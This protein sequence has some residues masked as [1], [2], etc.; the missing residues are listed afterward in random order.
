MNI[1]ILDDYQQVVPQLPCFSLLKEHQVQVFNDTPDS[2]EQ[3]VARLQHYE[4]L[5][6]IRERT[7]IDRAL[8][9]Q[10][11]NLRLIS[12][13]GRLSGHIDVEACTEFGVAIAEGQGSPV[14]PAEL[15]WA[16]VMAASRHIV[17]Y[18]M[19][20]QAGMW[21]SN[22]SLGLGRSLEGLTF[23][24]W[25]YGKIG[26]RIARYAQAFGM[27]VMI[28][29]SE[30]S[31]TLAVQDGFSAAP[32]RAA[33]FEQADI[34][35]LH[36]RLNE[37]TRYSVTQEDL[38]RM[39]TDAL[40][41]NI[42]RAELIAPGA[43]AAALDQGRPGF[44]ALDVFESE[45]ANLDNEP[46]LNRHNVLCTPHIGYVEHNSYELYFRT[47]FENLISFAQGQPQNIANPLALQVAR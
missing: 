37:E 19:H 41:V 11:P 20:L 27:H 30:Q 18:A 33:F 47:A 44:A 26:R 6:L 35:S 22:G 36:L 32:S 10:L 31:R 38:L 21:Q 12:Q 40:L 14:A 4:A 25:G 29:G 2:R 13:T 9:E 7:F 34:L 17:P 46:L 28:W 15:C 39:K 45:P 8:L 24:I 16:L 23:G 1:A 3:L 42:S 43:L 5:V